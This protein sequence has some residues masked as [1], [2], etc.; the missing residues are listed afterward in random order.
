MG[1]TGTRSRR[2]FCFQK[3]AL[4]TPPS[5]FHQYDHLENVRHLRL[6]QV[7]KVSTQCAGQE[8]RN[9]KITSSIILS[10]SGRR[11]S[12]SQNGGTSSSCWSTTAK[13]SWSKSFDNN[14]KSAT[15]SARHCLIKRQLNWP[16]RKS[17]RGT[18]YKN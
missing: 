15:R 18:T 5:Q 13:S 6:C 12:V 4:Q 9:E 16:C 11:L 2:G 1:V 3:L 14:A 8:V 17:Y 10:G 7:P